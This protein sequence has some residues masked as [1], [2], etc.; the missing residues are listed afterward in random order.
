MQSGVS[1]Q[2]ND[3]LGISVEDARTVCVADAVGHRFADTFGH[4]GDVGVNECLGHLSNALSTNNDGDH[5]ADVK[6][7]PNEHPGGHRESITIR[8]C[9]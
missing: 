2:H 8:D 5:D 9:V 1:E 6:L 4:R 7:V 3:F